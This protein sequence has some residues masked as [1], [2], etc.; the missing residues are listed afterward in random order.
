MTIRNYDFLALGQMDS[1]TWT[2]DERTLPYTDEK[3]GRSAKA[4]YI[5]GGR[6]CTFG[7]VRLG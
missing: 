3:S 4:P 7:G 6:C 5:F 1:W 2:F